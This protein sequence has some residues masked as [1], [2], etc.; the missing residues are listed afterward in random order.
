M[1]ARANGHG[2]YPRVRRGSNAPKPFHFAKSASGF[3]V[4]SGSRK[5]RPPARSTDGASRPPALATSGRPPAAGDGGGDLNRATLHAAATQRRQHL[6]HHRYGSSW[7]NC[8]CAAL[9]HAG[10]GLKGLGMEQRRAGS[11]A[12]TASELAWASCPAAA[13]RSCSC[14]ASQRHD[15]RQ[16][17]RARG[18]LRRA[19]PGDAAARLFRP[20]RQRRRLRRTARSGAGLQDAL[21]VIDAADRGAAA[22][23]R[24]VDGRLDRA[25]D[26]RWRGRSGSPALV[27]IAAAPDF[28]E[29]LMWEAMTPPERATLMRDGRLRCA[30]PVRRATARS[31]AR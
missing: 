25:A 6:Q 17:D 10:N 15:R 5:L 27:G 28:T 18:V 26:R 2:R 14:P 4:C 8:S 20:R 29:T 9:Y 19:R 11:I 7:A 21:A 22:A 1:P 24:L 12:A 13:R 3:L 30:Q 23:G 16:G 31:P